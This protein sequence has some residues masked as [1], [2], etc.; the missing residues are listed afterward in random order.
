MSMQCPE[1]ASLIIKEDTSDWEG[2]PADDLLVCENHECRYVLH[3]TDEI[4]EFY[5]WEEAHEESYQDMLMQDYFLE[6]YD[7]Q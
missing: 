3:K 4:N 6:Q 7:A 2:N 1:C 5:V